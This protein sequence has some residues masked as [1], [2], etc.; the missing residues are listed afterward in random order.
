MS[1]I[2]KLIIKQRFKKRY[3]AHNHAYV[4]KWTTDKNKAVLFM[5][6]QEA[7]V[8]LHK[9]NPDIQHRSEVVEYGKI[10]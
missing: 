6:R 9:F 10:T 3:L 4:Y 2:T 8:L 7:Y 5:T 1:K